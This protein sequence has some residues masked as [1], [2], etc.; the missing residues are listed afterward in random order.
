M[1]ARPIS[2]QEPCLVCGAAGGHDEGCMVV[3]EPDAIDILDAIDSDLMHQ[4]GAKM[5]R[6][7]VEQEAIKAADKPVSTDI[8]DAIERYKWVCPEAVELCFSMSAD[9]EIHIIAAGNKVHKAFRGLRC[10]ECGK[11][12]KLQARCWADV[13]PDG[14]LGYGHS[15]D[16]ECQYYCGH[17]D[18]TFKHMETVRG[19]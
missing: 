9:D 15:E 19:E 4:A 13:L 1:T 18:E 3:S 2:Q 12:D 8:L 6:K 14:T 11:S 10:P 17:C 7:K 16:A 5:V